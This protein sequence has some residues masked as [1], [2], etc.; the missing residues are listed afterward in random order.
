MKPFK[1]RD[2]FR[3]REF[4]ASAHGGKRFNGSSS[5]KFDGPKRFDRNSDRLERKFSHKDSG[6]A[7]KGFILHEA[8]CDRCGRKCD[9][10]FKPTGNKPIY[11][12]SCFRQNNSENDFGKNFESKKFGD[13]HESNMPITS[14]EELE[15]I[16]QKLDKIMKALKIN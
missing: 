11:C 3:G 1:K 6:I 13:R 8:V 10:P 7:D 16:N 15:S 2:N 4:D 14:S 9:L 5:R 12:R